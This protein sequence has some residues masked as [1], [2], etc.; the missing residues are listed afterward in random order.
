MKLLYVVHRYAP[1]Q[2]GSEIYVKNMAEESARQGH[3]VAVFAGEH[4]GDYNNIRVSNNARILLEDWDL[5]IVH[6]GDVNVQNFVL[7][8]ATNIRSPILYLLILPSNSDVCIRALND[9]AFIGCSTVQD[10]EHCKNHNVS[11]KAV[12]VRHGINWIECQGKSGFKEKYN[13][14]YN[15][16]MFLACGGYW[17]NKA[18]K[19]L[20]ELFKVADLDNAV[21]VTTGYE[22]R[23]NIMPNASENIFPFM[24]NDRTDVLSAI[25]EADCVLMHSYQEGFGLILLESMF[26][27]TPW[28]AR[29]IAGANLLNKYGKTYESDAELISILKKFSRA[30]FDIEGAYNLVCENHLIKNTV[31][32]II[33][34]ANRIS[35]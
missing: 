1:Y 2:G 31:D 22:D 7:S 25:Y 13:I 9:V 15:K 5:I 27:Q 16:T 14:P 33:N 26:N 12:S 21:L 18:I 8:N 32:D 29:N 17:P 3:T 6:G 11:N 20:A 34:V 30:S 23:F 24:L 35:K 10:W 19:E 28:I 4:Q